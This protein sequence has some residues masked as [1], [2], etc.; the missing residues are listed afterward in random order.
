MTTIKIKKIHSKAIVPRLATKGSACFD[1]RTCEDFV[2]GNGRFHKV[3]TGLIFEIPKGWHIK[4]Y[5]RSGIA[6]KGIIIPNAPGII[7][8]DYRGEIMVMLYGLF[9]RKQEIFQIGNRIAQGELIKGE[10]VEFRVVSKLSDTERG[11]GG[12]GSTGK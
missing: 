10:P 2:L 11:S 9:M 7:D 3:R 8:S 6:V 4:L 1:L 5:N 12:F